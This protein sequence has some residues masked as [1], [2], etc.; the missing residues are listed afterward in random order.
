MLTRLDTITLETTAPI[1]LVDLTEQLRQRCA[2]SGVRDGLVTLLSRHTTASICLNERETQLQRDMVTFLKRL[3]PRDGD[4]LHNLAPVDDRD[5]AHAHLLALFTNASETIPIAD[6]E[7]LLGG[8]QS[9]FFVE[10]DG[11][12]PERSVTLQ[13]LGQAQE[14]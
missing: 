2:L 6:G 3:V 10:L 5:N 7:L 11:P 13:F 4:Y 8:W 14:G 1:Q 9:V 12:R